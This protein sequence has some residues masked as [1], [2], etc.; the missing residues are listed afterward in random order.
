LVPQNFRHFFFGPFLIFFKMITSVRLLYY[1]SQLLGF[2]LCVV[3]VW[4]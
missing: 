3:S 1:Y 2:G 4:S